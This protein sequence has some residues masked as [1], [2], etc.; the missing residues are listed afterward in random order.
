MFN[1]SVIYL[2]TIKSVSSIR[3]LSFVFV[4]AVSNIKKS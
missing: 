2:V 4:A 3:E 1:V